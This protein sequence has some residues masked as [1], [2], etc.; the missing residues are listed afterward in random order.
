[1]VPLR[2]SNGKQTEMQRELLIIAVF[3]GLFG[4][5]QPTHLAAAPPEGATPAQWRV[6]WKN[7]PATRATISWSTVEPGENH[8]VHLRAD[9]EDS[10]QIVDCQRNGRFSARK[11]GLNLYYHHTRLDGLKPATKYYV[12]L[13]SD[14]KKSP[15]MYFVTAPALDAP[16][17]ILFGGDSRSD[18]GSRRKINALMRR[19]MTEAASADRPP[20]VALAHGGDYVNRGYNVEQWSAWM[21]DHEITTTEDGRML[22]IIPARGNHDLGK[23]FNEVFDFPPEDRNYYAQNLGPRVR[24][25]T[26]NSETTSG[27][28]QQKWLEQELSASRKTH[29]WILAQY[30]SPAYPAVKIP[31]PAFFFWVPLFEKYNVDMICE[32]DGHCIKRTAPIRNHKIDPTGVVY[33]GEGGLGVGQRTPKSNRWYL[34]SPLAKCGRGHHVQLL[35]FTKERMTY[36]AILLDGHVFDEHHYSPRGMAK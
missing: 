12:T 33:I 18:W 1:M 36:R 23:P 21:S 19:L 24:F 25:I 17:S 15:E 13:D 22:P 7:D 14:G 2:L 30:H 9:G 26:L 8:Q 29:R 3:A 11:E 16:I 4:L 35:T 5:H 10:P 6:I 32:A 20:I 27:G 31:S 34:N 28:D